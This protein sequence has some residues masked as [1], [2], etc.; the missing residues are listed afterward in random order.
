ME[1][2]P[3]SLPKDEQNFVQSF[4]INQKEEI[5]QFFN[6]Y[7]FVVVN[8]ILDDSEV[9]ATVNEIWAE[10]IQLSSCIKQSVH[11]PLVVR[12]DPS[13]WKKTWP[14]RGV[15]VFLTKLKKIIKN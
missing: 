7:G 12:Y 8:N 3:I 4:T 5:R 11:N 15:G 1:F 14:S 10:V 2:K 6:Q 9:E 13:T